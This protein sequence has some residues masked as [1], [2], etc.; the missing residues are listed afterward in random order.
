MNLLKHIK[1]R[2]LNYCSTD[3]ARFYVPDNKIDWSIEYSDYKPEYYDSPVLEGKP[4][5]DPVIGNMI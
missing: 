5:A 4:W 3:I 2:N 1:C